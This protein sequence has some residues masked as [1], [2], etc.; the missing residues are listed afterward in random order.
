MIRRRKT[1]AS[2]AY[3][4]S[5]PVSPTGPSREEETRLAY[6]HRVAVIAACR[7]VVFARDRECRICHRRPWHTD[8]MHEIKS[9][10]QLRGKRPED[11]FCPENCVRLCRDC[12]RK[13]TEHEVWI[14][15]TDER[16]GANSTIWVAHERR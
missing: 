6:A 13:V 16:L 9:R 11:I 15:V 8:E 10:A 12:H 2:A 7:V 14:S 5:S 1:S 3:K 4:Q